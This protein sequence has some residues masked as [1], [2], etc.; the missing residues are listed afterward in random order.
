M[1]EM[2]PRENRDYPGRLDHPEKRDPREGMVHR[3]PRPRRKTGNNA[4]GG[5]VMAGTKD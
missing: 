1:D 4:R 5:R 3:P 2:G